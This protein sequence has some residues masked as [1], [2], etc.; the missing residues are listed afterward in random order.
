MAE[1][2]PDAGTGRVV[3]RRMTERDVPFTVA[4][5]NEQDTGRWFFKTE[6]LTV[7]GSTR[8]FRGRDPATDWDF[9]AE[10]D[11]E[12]VGYI[13]IYAVDLVR[14]IGEFGGW[15]IVPSARGSDVADQ[16]GRALIAEAKAAG[17]VW[18]HSLGRLA[19]ERS[20]RACAKVGFHIEPFP[21]EGTFLATLNPQT[22]VGG[23]EAEPVGFGPQ[24]G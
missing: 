16:M 3:L 15:M 21:E 19:N 4:L 1:D 9:I 12:P 5:R 24:R 13:A 8:W 14:G 17:L 22:G 23:P 2:R 18:L 6:K 7:E 20:A 10:R 11:G